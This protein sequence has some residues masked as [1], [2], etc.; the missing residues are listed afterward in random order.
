[1]PVTR[2]KGGVLNSSIKPIAER[3]GADAR[4][5][6]RGVTIAFLDAG[7]FGHPDLCK[8]TNRVKEFHDVLSRE[9]T[10]H[11][12][13]AADVSSW[14]GM[15]TSVVACGNGELS[16]GKYKG[17]AHESELVLVKVGSVSRVRH[18]DIT[19]GIDWVCR[20]RERLGI[21][22]LNISCGGDYEASYLW[23]SLSRAAE[24]AVR[25]GIVV[26]CAAGNRGGDPFEHACVPPASAPAVITVGG[27]DDEHGP[28]LERLVP[29]HSS[30]GWTIDGIQKPEVIAPAIRVAAP[31]LPDTPT[32]ASA[33]LIA[34]LSAA[35]DHELKSIL[36]AH[37]G[38]DA[39]FDAARDLQPYQIRQLIA[40]KRGTE[41]L[42]HKHYKEVDGT[43][44][45][46]PIIASV[47][48]QMLEARPDLTPQSVKQIL[49]A[50]AK[51]MPS[52]SP[53]RQGWGVV[54]P[55]AAVARALEWPVRDPAVPW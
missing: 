18:D 41:K 26:V 24:A 29:Y 8:P 46:A 9:R 47:V 3:L 21:R 38:V 1:M 36:G 44:F 48:A 40:V 12:L 33:A 52:A 43:S 28:Q 53:D 22:V 19:L 23:D 39:D 32:A 11:Q 27:F 45:A 31:I 55:A 42:V 17:L 20:H 7:F 37:K 25:A 16:G 35:D 50:T 2:T 51:R 15:M 13:G 14:H 6:G 5:A 54:Q 30:Y 10:P 34:D 49:V 4:F